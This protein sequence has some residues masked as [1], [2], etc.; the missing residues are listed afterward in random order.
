MIGHNYPLVQVH[1][2]EVF[3]NLPPAFLHNLPDIRELRLVIYD[4]P[5]GRLL[6]MSADC[7]EE[8]P[9]EGVVKPTQPDRASSLIFLGG[10]M[11]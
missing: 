10:H 1:V 7:D 9:S 3:G 5:Q 2:S 8:E 4:F 6:V 11:T